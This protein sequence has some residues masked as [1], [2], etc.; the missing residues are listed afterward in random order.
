MD[1]AS[2]WQ[3]GAGSEEDTGSF[4][5]GEVDSHC[6]QVSRNAMILSQSSP[7]LGKI[8]LSGGSWDWDIEAKSDSAASGIA[9][10]G[11]YTWKSLSRGASEDFWENL[12]GLAAESAPEE[13]ESGRLLRYNIF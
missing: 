1:E 7:P 2:N 12:L 5:P 11:I 6:C 10:W 13:A 3:E 8:I 9:G 4:S